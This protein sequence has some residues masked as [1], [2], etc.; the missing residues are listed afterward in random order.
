M[1]SREIAVVL[2]FIYIYI[3]IYVCV[4]VCMY[5]L[6]RP[7]LCWVAVAFDK[8]LY[9]SACQQVLGNKTLKTRLKGKGEKKG[10]CNFILSKL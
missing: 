9:I 8:V 6:R 5:I 2:G 3:I 4:C 7:C 10:E 1:G